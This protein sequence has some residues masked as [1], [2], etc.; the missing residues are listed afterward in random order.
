MI[1]PYSIIVFREGAVP[2]DV[3][4]GDIMNI[5]APWEMV[6]SMAL[7]ALQRYPGADRVIVV[8]NMGVT[9]WEWPVPS[10]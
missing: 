6:I 7:I 8:D 4:R 1:E 2:P 10:V 3:S 9:K 5:D